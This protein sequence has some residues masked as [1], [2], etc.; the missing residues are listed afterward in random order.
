MEGWQQ[1][2]QNQRERKDRLG[3][4][5]GL[6]PI[7]NNGK[8]RVHNGE[9]CNSSCIQRKG[10][11]GE[12]PLQGP[13]CWSAG[14]EK[15]AGKVY[16]IPLSKVYYLEMQQ[17]VGACVPW[18]VVN[19]S[20]FSLLLPSSNLS[21]TVLRPSIWHCQPFKKFAKYCCCVV[22]AHHVQSL[23]SP[24]PWTAQT[25]HSAPPT[26]LPT[27]A[28]FPLRF[29]FCFLHIR[30][31][32]LFLTKTGFQLMFAFRMVY[33]PQSGARQGHGPHFLP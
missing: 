18:T 4:R 11:A 3:W 23:P 24:Q 20:L 15:A 16:Q 30:P 13:G 26:N 10:A 5:G 31:I 32:F 25:L 22:L 2:N 27:P 7:P 1:Q 8:R 29:S 14:R 21:R 6:M 17:R 19:I 28:G 33:P 9:L 12:Y